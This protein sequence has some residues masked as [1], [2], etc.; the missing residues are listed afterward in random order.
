MAAPIDSEKANLQ[1]ILE[2]HMQ[3]DLLL[4]FEFIFGVQLFTQLLTFEI[5]CFLN[6]F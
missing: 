3:S 1:S 2:P 6:V 5:L 4:L